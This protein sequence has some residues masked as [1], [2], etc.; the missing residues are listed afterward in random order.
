M[1]MKWNAK[2]ECKADIRKKKN[3]NRTVRNKENWEQS[4]S[5]NNKNKHVMI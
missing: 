2:P 1:R 3:N 5:K 4:A